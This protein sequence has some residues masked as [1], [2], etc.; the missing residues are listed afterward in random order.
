MGLPAHDPSGEVKRWEIDES[1]THNLTQLKAS[2]PLR[3]FTYGSESG[4]YPEA[5]HLTGKMMVIHLKM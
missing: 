2:C 1:L 4:V 3:G 5:S